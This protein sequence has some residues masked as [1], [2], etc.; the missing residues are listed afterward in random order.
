LTT[1]KTDK[2]TDQERAFNELDCLEM[3]MAESFEKQGRGQTML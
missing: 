3:Q 1:L 2:E